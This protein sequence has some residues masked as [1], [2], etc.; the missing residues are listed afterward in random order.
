MDETV[1]I[2]VTN[3]NQAD[4]LHQALDSAIGQTYDHTEIVVVDAASEDESRA[5]ITE[6][7]DRY[8]E[9]IRPVLLETDPGIPEMRNIGLEHVAGDMFTFLDADDWFYPEKIKKEVS[10]Y[11]ENPD[12]NVVYSNFEYVKKD[13]TE[14]DQWANKSAPEGDVLVDVLAR[15]YPDQTLWRSALVETSLLDTIGM[16]DE[17]LP[18]YEDWEFKIRVA[19]AS[20]VA[21]CPTVLS[22]YRLHDEG[23]SS[24]ATE[25]AH[26]DALRYI[27]QKHRDTFRKTED[28][29]VNAAFD[30][31][32]KIVHR[33][34]ALAQ[35]SDGKR[36]L[37]LWNYFQ[38]LTKYPE[39]L[40][41]YNYHLR[42]TL[43]KPIF[44]LLKRLRD[45]ILNDT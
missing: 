27:V 25:Q 29:E 14:I 13:G 43:P 44:F 7:A 40:S 41:R 3:Y 35:L 19:R 18:I 10:V 23:I 4:V 33:R 21:Y 1:S 12:T 5:I 26:S 22:V 6:Y 2:I 39:E 34:E 9:M 36:F 37:A 11:R 28:A 45:R 8:P 17:S 30:E 32:V 24:R 38:F 31:A 16:Y 42:M 20:T 15:Q